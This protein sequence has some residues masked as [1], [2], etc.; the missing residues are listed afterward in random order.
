MSGL[1]SLNKSLRTAKVTPD[2]GS[3]AQGFRLFDVNMQCE[4]P[5]YMIDEYGRPA[6]MDA[7][8]A[9]LGNGAPGCYSSEYR[10]DVE[11]ILRPQ[12]YYYLDVPQGIMK[13]GFS[14]YQNRPHNDLMG[15]NRDRAFGYDGMYT[16]GSYPQCNNATDK[17]QFEELGW[18]S[19]NLAR[20]YDSRL[21]LRSADFNSG[22]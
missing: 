16:A 5:Q 2:P 20:K 13:G 12:Y 7:G 4:I 6:S 3:V 17:C 10:I 14:E 11:N 8:L 15:M 21:W 22:F 18:E 19:A 1:V 9:F